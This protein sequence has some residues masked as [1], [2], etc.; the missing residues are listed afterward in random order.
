MAAAAAQDGTSRLLLWGWL[1]ELPGRQQAAQQDGPRASYAGAIS[2]PRQLLLSPE[3]HLLQQPLP[4]LALLHA[5][6]AWSIKQLQLEPCRPRHIGA[7]IPS[8]YFD[9]AVTLL[10]AAAATDAAADGSTCNTSCL[11]GVVLPA[12]AATNS[13]SSSSDVAVAA[14]GAVLLYDFASCE[15]VLTVGPAVGANLLTPLAS[16]AEVL[17][18]YT[19][20][21]LAAA[22][23]GSQNSSGCA[24]AD[25]A[26]RSGSRH[27]GMRAGVRQLQGKLRLAR[28]Q[29][30]Q[31]RLLMDFSLLEVFCGDGQVLSTR[32]Y[33]GVWVTGSST[34]GSGAAACAAGGDGTSRAGS[35]SDAS[36][37]PAGVATAADGLAA[38]GV[39]TRTG[40]SSRGISNNTTAAAATA[41]QQSRGQVQHA[42][43]QADAEAVVADNV[44]RSASN[45][46]GVYLLAV[47]GGAV[48]SGVSMHAM[49][50]A[51]KDCDKDNNGT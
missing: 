37:G 38:A 3:G 1:S 12:W 41:P 33:R 18:Q 28:G 39:D 19:P 40:H 42:A 35:S 7:G 14:Q 5:G 23:V 25:G 27:A 4:E 50:S 43:Q 13:S 34:G 8:S 46:H 48:A 49:G 29:P 15:L 32:L 45:M 2:L 47:G 11:A 6:P 22:Q 30:L 16:P 36:I 31:L 10:P 44:V 51:W 26:G 9:L 20:A 17:A 24:A 21:G